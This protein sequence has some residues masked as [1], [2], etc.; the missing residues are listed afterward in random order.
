[1][2][3]K[4]VSEDLS[5]IMIILEGI[6]KEMASY[7]NTQWDAAYPQ[8]QDFQADI[9]KQE[10]Y[11]SVRDSQVVG[12]ICINRDEPKEY[13]G[14]SWASKKEALVIHRMGVSSKHRKE[15]IGTELIQ[16]AERLASDNC[17]NYLKTDTYSL[18]QKMQRLFLKNGYVFV[19]EMRFKGK[20]NPFYCYEKI[21]PVD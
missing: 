1:M 14:L 21:L 8:A 3:R 10:L 11:V 19:G 15:G 17:V 12:F 13:D 6:I 20:E 16:L 4:A 5:D 9:E 2:I 7:N 18:N